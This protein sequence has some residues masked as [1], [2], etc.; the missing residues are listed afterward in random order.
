MKYILVI[1]IAITL[2]IY[3]YYFCKRN[4]KNKKNNLGKEENINL[5]NKNSSNNRMVVK[6]EE[7]PLETIENCKSMFE[8]TDNKILGHIDNLV[9]GL[10]QVGTATNNAIQA[11]SSV[12]YQAIIPAGATLTKSNS[13]NNAVRGMYHGTNGIKGHANF[14]EV[15]QTGKAVSNTLSTGISV[16]SM[17]VGQYYMT[18]INSELTKINEE[19]SKISTFQ[20]N[21][22]KSKI[23]ALVIQIKRISTFQ[24]EIMENQQLRDFDI[25][26]LNHLEQNCIELLGQANLTIME[27]TKKDDLDYK[28]YNNQLTEIHNWY[29]YQKTLLE[30]LY[31]ITDLKNIL[32]VGAISKE[33]LN[34]IPT[35]YTKQVM[36]VHDL[37]TKWHERITKKL[38]IDTETARR[39]RMGFDGVI[40]WIPGLFKDDFNFCA[41]S[42]RTKTM[43]KEQ[44]SNY[45][46]TSQDKDNLF[47]KDAKII[48]KDGKLYYLPQ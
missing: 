41:I 29:I 9:P 5:V 45:N 43:I 7:L 23:L 4:T 12:V 21:E 40:H 28:K 34:I 22:Y 1:L 8:I 42:E 38:G 11:N 35:T 37:L 25:D 30:M 47:D 27:F 33:Q 39:K 48:S 46:V 32:Y 3:L 44:T 26:K 14:V 24:T 10:I 18:Q 19:I 2:G 17:I 36:E 16:T 20:D 15:N 6:V 13:M 31:K